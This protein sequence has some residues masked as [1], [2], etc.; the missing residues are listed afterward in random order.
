M[1][2]LVTGG[3][4]YI[5][6][7]MA[8]Q[9][10]DSGH[11]VVVVDSL[12]KGKRD[13][14]DTRAKLLIGNLDD[15]QFLESVLQEGFEVVI[16]FAG[17]IEVGESMQD[18][19]KYFDNN[20]F[21]TLGLLEGMRAY[22]TKKIIFSS[23]AAVYGNPMKTPI[24]EDHPK[25][26]TSPYGDSKYMTERLLHWYQDIYGISYVS[27]RYFNACGAALDGSLGE[28]HV[29]ETHIIPN[30]ISAVL[31]K[32]KFSLFGNDYQTQDGTCIRDYIHI[33]DLITAHVLAIEKLE[34]ETGG[35]T[36]NVGTGRGYSN[37][38]VLDMVK[39]VSGV[40]IE[41]VVEPRRFGDPE[42]L[43]ADP[44]NIQRDLGFT[45]KHSDLETIVK[46]AWE[47]HKNK[48]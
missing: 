27:L 25:N 37:K 15:S 26:P 16:H 48:K 34:K 43:I 38:E 17:S 30:A 40:A 21:V 1:K 19:K 33:N 44:E 41:V 36:Y 12:E 9:L 5:G 29:P 39:K 47:W 23:T 31:D 28:A 3:A 35:F 8:K 45:P 13:A 14:V 20:T 10:L 46:S 2:I 18:P 32:G 6:S 4:G 7:F 24:P 42:V 22:N 11:T